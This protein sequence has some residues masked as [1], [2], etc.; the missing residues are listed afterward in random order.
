MRVLMAAAVLAALG[1]AQISAQE[2]PEDSIKVEPGLSAEEYFNIGNWYSE[3]EQ[4]FKAVA[5][6]KEATAVKADFAEAWNN[7]GTSFSA[8]ARYSEAVQAYR[9]AIE[10]GIKEHFVYLNLGNAQ[11]N[12][13]LL[14]D[15]VASYRVFIELEPY[16]AGGYTNLG[17]TLFRLKEYSEAA[18]AFEKLLLI[19]K[20]DS[21]FTFQAARCY[22]LAGK[23]DEALIK[24]RAALA[25]DPGVRQVLLT[26]PD[27]RGFRRS[28][29][30]RE[31]DTEK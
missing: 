13:G 23:Y 8:V 21:Y 7:L 19:N 5:Y 9:K 29:Q 17:I 12:A 31:L 2:K 18:D 6:Y 26:D 22:A 14:R 25:L 4:H 27:F 20:D 16:D 3:R 30:F 1:A 28:P 10:L 24:V 11:V 15:A